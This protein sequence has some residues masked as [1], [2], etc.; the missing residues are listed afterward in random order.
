MSRTVKV[1][2]LLVLL[3]LLVGKSIG[4]WIG[5][6]F[7]SFVAALLSIPV[8]GALQVIVVRLRPAGPGSQQG[9]PRRATRTPPCRAAYSAGQYHESHHRLYRR[10]IVGLTR[11]EPM[12]LSL[13]LIML[14]F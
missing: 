6:F 10:E 2:P 4:D 11:A 1:N 8:A 3:S 7:G 9:P 13:F 14:R 12:P 5:G